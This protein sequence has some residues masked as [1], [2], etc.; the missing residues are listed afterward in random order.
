MAKIAIVQT[1]P[2]F[3][4]KTE[5]IKLAVEKIEEAVDQGADLVDGFFNLLHRRGVH[6]WLSRLDMAAETWR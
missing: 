6:T 4:D 3:L 2:V 5:T 1:A